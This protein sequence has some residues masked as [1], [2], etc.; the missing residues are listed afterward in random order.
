MYRLDCCLFGCCTPRSTK[1]VMIT[2]GRLP[3]LGKKL[4][5]RHGRAISFKKALLNLAGIVVV[6][7]MILRLVKRAWIFPHLF[8]ESA[9]V[10]VAIFY[11]FCPTS[12]LYIKNF[13]Y[14]YNEGI[15]KDQNHPRFSF[16][17]FLISNNLEGK[18]SE[19]I[20]SLLKH[21]S[22][23]PE[24]V[25]IF[26]KEN[27]CFDLG[28]I[29]WLLEKDRTILTKYRY[30]IWINAS[31]RGPFIAPYA[32]VHWTDPFLMK[33]N[34]TVKLVGPTINCGV[35]GSFKYL[36]EPHPHVQSFVSA[37]DQDGMNILYER[38]IF[39]CHESKEQAIENGEIMA[40]KAI[41]EM[42]FT[43]AS[44]MA[45]QDIYW[46]SNVNTPACN[47]LN[48]PMQTLP[49]MEGIPLDVYE[50]IFVKVK[51]DLHVPFMER[52]V[53]V[54]AWKSGALTCLREYYMQ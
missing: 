2:T 18:Q 53:A 40:S 19:S 52:A 6:M 3:S 35:P 31:V 50:V 1:M 34:D 49:D 5:Y 54:S 4:I 30:Y 47:S 29:G 21:C 12:D 22:R 28:S 32:G 45:S 27:S 9:K 20:S 37:T 39:R 41:M 14:F 44:L 24:N 16:D 51:P 48:D 8:W 36:K 38:G 13:I 23:P 46:S 25:R 15:L 10:P 43:I 17:Y 11:V 26:E 33:L 7:T 42:N